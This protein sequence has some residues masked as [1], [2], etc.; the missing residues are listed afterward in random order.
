MASFENAVSMVANYIVSND[1]YNFQSLSEDSQQKL[2]SA[3]G[4][5]I[6]SCVN[7]QL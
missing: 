6:E 4:K 2:I 5:E 7:A 3:Y 1:L